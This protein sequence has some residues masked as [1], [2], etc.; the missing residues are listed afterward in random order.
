M[1]VY[2]SFPMSSRSFDELEAY[3][4]KT[5]IELEDH[6]YQVLHPLTATSFLRSSV[7]EHNGYSHPEATDRACFSRDKAMVQMADVIYCNCVEFQKPST[8]C[9]YEL[10]WA[11]VYNKQVILACPHEQHAFVKQSIG[12]QFDSHPESMSYLRKLRHGFI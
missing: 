10:A 8:G 11:E 4:I 6:G 5:K 9:L 2:L 7:I 3:V 1:R 12:I